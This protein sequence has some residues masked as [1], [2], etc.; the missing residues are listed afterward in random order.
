MNKLVIT[1]LTC[2]HQTFEHLQLEL[3]RIV[4]PGKLTRSFTIIKMV[5][6]FSS[7]FFSSLFAQYL[8]KIF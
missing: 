7:I 6:K 5:K 1:W 8:L 3:T 4:G 2:S